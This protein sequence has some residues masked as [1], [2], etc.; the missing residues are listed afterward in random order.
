M[1]SAALA[2]LLLFQHLEPSPYPAGAGA[3]VTVRVR[4][5]E[6]KPVGGVVVQWSRDGGAPGQ[7]PATDAEGTVRW[8]PPGTGS[9]LYRAS[10]P[11]PA[12][13]D[14]TLR[15]VAPHEVVALRP[16]LW[17]VLAFVPLGLA[18]LWANLRRK[19]PAAA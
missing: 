5:G 17:L 4:D 19:P 13:P 7:L 14:G 15:L 8:I 2:L 3:E 12:A 6:G 11:Q 16:R 9:Y 1:T 18:L 10:L